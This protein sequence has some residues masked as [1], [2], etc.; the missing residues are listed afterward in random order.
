MNRRE[1]LATA[2]AIALL[3]MPVL[4][5]Q[6]ISR[7]KAEVVMKQLLPG[8]AGMTQMLGF[9]GSMPGPEL[10]F[11]RGE[12]VTL[13]VENGLDIGTSVHWHGIRLVNEMDGVPDLTQRLIEPGATKTYS[14]TPP[15]SGTFWYHSHQNSQ[16]QVARGMA[17]A[18]IVE[19]ETP[20][21]VDHDIT[22]LMS[23][24]LM[25]DDGSL[26]DSFNQMHMV[27][28]GGYMGN[29][30]RAFLST[31]QVQTGDRVRLR[32]INTATN[33]VFPVAV[34]GVEGKVVALDGMPL[35]QPRDLG[36]ISLA[37]AQRADLIVDVVGPVGFDMVSG[38]GGY[39]LADLV[40]EGTNTVREAS[41][42][43]PLAPHNL[44]APGEVSQNLELL[45]QGGAM[46][47]RHGGDDIW[48]LNDVSNLADAPFGSFSRGETVRITMV[49]ETSF[50]HGMHLHGHHFYEVGADGTLGDLR[51]TTL[52][53]ARESQEILCVFDNPGKWLLHC[54]MLSHAAGGMRTWVNVA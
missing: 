38:N 17:G 21:D 28:H 26:S 45:L 8:D 19:D 47:G 42:I 37:P 52:V 22:V 7:L 34:S 35:A 25:N 1:F 46:G 53:N 13:D 43:A 39:R 2:S 41:A 16:E 12:E 54:H 5:R 32:L 44:P 40:V 3:P 23:D 48:G 6:N 50:P 33:R 15:D 51:D 11:T 29:F 20:P 4:A 36:Q 31:E 27:S 9:N 30:A 10:R 14:Y 24:W 49:N 18:L